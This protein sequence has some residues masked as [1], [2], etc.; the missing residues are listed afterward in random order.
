LR[1]AA[2]RDANEGEIVAALEAIGALVMKIN[3][4]DLPDLLV[5][6]RG[7]LHMIE[8]KMPGEKLRPGQKSIHGALMGYP[9]YVAQSPLEAI[10]QVSK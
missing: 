3:Q 10:Q 4:R 2:K 8:V 6:F 1:V 7:K 5:A 9:V